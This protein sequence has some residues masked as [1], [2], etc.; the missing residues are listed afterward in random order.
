MTKQKNVTIRDV[1][2][3]AGCSTS[4][5]CIALTDKGR[6]SAKT[7]QRILQVAEQIGYVPNRS[8]QSLARKEI[9]I[10]FVLPRKP[11]VLQNILCSNVQQTVD[12][13]LCKTKCLIEQYDQNDAERLRAL[14]ALEGKIDGLILEMNDPKSKEL[15]TYLEKLQ[16]SGLPIVAL[17][18]GPSCLR[19]VATVSIN[20]EACAGMAAQILV[21]HGCKSV[22]MIGG[23]DKTEI[24]Q[25][26]AENFKIQCKQNGL[27]L[28]GI[29]NSMD[30]PHTAYEI[31]RQCLQQS[32]LPDGFFVTSYL[33]PAVCA[34]VRDSGM[35]HIK[36]VGTDFFEEVQTWLQNG[37][38]CATIFQN[39]QL[40]AKTAAEI[41]L[42][43]VLHQPLDSLQNRCI[44]KPELILRS[45]A[46]CYAAPPSDKE[47][48]FT[49]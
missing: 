5:V 24:H 12:N 21:L 39:Q 16:Q 30:N 41:L 45:N 23:E 36:I 25:H 11:S 17:V 8:A 9:T 4:L 29:H 46:H 33:S 43:Y 28:L 6:I 10:G 47:F 15:E 2:A 49:K 26:M 3:K 13:S 34:A 48:D 31:T 37:Q 19:T 40:Q 14:Q 42:N 38:L 44:I 7:K 20:K 27:T 35:S 18:A 1:A 32:P 22:C